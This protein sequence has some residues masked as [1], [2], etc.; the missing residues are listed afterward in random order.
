MIASLIKS[1]KIKMKAKIRNTEIFFD[2]TGLQSRFDGKKFVEKPVLFILHG[3]P[4][5]D[6]QSNKIHSLALQDVAQLVF[7]DHRGCGRSKKTFQKDYTLENNIDDVEALRKYLGLERICILGTSYGGMVAQGYAIRYPKQ[8]DKLILAATA[9]SYR[10]IEEAKKILKRDGNA[11]QIA[12]CETLWAGKFK[13]PKALDKF[14]KIMGPLY[15]TSPAKKREKIYGKIHVVW[16][17]EALNEGFGRFLRTFDFVPKLKRISAPTLIL[18]A[19]KDWIIGPSQTKTL[20]EHI[21]NAKLVTFQK[22][23]HLLGLDAN[24]AYISAIK[25]FLAQKPVKT[26]SKRKGK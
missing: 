17:H 9:P 18:G 20:A 21:P 13:N 3:G 24:S 10:F 16:S 2:I 4:G 25:K 7:I 5:G 1:D 26:K 22:S 8:V 23:G 12:A 15:S 19:K 11:K 6:Q 14:F